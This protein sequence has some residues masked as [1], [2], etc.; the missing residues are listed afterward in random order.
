MRKR[1]AKV[2]PSKDLQLKRIGKSKLREDVF[3]IPSPRK[4]KIFNNY[5]ILS[6]IQ[7]V[8]ITNRTRSNGSVF[9]NG[10]ITHRSKIAKSG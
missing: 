7:Y 6:Y 10:D 4:R 5:K 8:K 1:N 2:G 9:A 3:V